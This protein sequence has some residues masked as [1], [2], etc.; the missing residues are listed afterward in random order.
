MMAMKT[1]T[2][3]ELLVEVEHLLTHLGAQVQ[4]PSMTIEGAMTT[5]VELD[6]KEIYLS[7]SKATEARLWIS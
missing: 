1:P 6:L 5:M 2:A 4:E 3:L 7:T